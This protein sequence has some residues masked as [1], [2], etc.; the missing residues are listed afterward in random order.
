MP[1]DHRAACMISSVDSNCNFP[2][3][4]GTV[5]R[6]KVSGVLRKRGGDSGR[7]GFV[8]F[9]RTRTFCSSKGCHFDNQ[10]VTSTQSM[11]SMRSLAKKTRQLQCTV[12][13]VAQ[14]L[15]GTSQ[16]SFWQER[17]YSSRVRA[18]GRWDQ[19][20]SV[21][22]AYSKRS[23]GSLQGDGMSQQRK[24][25]DHTSKLRP[26]IRDHRDMIQGLQEKNAEELKRHNA[27][28]RSR[29]KLRYE[30]KI[31]RTSVG[32]PQHDDMPLPG[33]AIKA[34]LHVEKK[35]ARTEQGSF[36]GLEPVFVPS[37]KKADERGKESHGDKP[38]PNRLR[39]NRTSVT[40]RV[41][42][43]AAAVASLSDDE[44]GSAFD[45]ILDDDAIK[46]FYHNEPPKDVHV[47]DTLAEAKRIAAL[48]MGAEM[49]ERTFA[50]DTEVMDIDV[51]RESPCCHGVVTC[52]SIYCGSDV[53]FSQGNVTGDPK[54]TMLWVDTWL[55]G[56]DER[57]EEAKDIMETFKPFFESDSHKKVWHNYSF[58]RHVM[59]RMGVKCNGFYG[60]TMH[61]AR[62][63]DSSRTGRGGYSLE[64]LTSTYI[65]KRCLLQNDT[66]EF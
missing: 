32:H 12:E 36:S 41:K 6:K 54:K 8:P 16:S 39:D 66:Y 58:D 3:D 18:S 29:A 11:I 64:A 7:R 1:V 42:R 9:L 34:S 24:F 45:E 23:A 25:G 10:G 52:F 40:P 14:G 51:T 63:W 49:Q 57:A 26:S 43:E 20:E 31:R 35:E 62:L 13:N 19:G 65:F 27:T 59:E 21:K 47:V 61:M 33:K 44:S 37:T 2:R 46:K 5:Y 56:E 30:Q 28:S 48:L 55:N 38:R 60:D 50:C 53:D 4:K 15:P 22:S 17:R